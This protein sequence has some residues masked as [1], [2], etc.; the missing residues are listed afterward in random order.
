MKKEEYYKK[1][2]TRFID[3]VNELITHFDTDVNLILFRVYV[4]NKLADIDL[5]GKFM[6][7][8]LPFKNIVKNR[9]ESFFESYDLTNNDNYKEDNDINDNKIKIFKDLWDSDTLDDE[10]REIM[11]KWIESLIN[12]CDKYY[13]EHMYIKGYEFNLN[14]LN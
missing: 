13:N 1:F 14:Y 12:F 10:D 11:W 3:F 8:C 4:Q 7:N 6:K 2:K 5:M 9:D